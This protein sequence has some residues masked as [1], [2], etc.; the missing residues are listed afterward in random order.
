MFDLSSEQHDYKT[1]VVDPLG[2]F[3][4]LVFASVVGPNGG[5]IEEYGGGYGK[6]YTA[7]LQKW[8]EML[9]LLERCWKARGMNIILLGHAQVKAFQNP[10]GPSYDKWELALHAKTAGMLRQ[11]VDAVLFARLE[12][13]VEVK[14]GQK[15]RGLSSGARVVHTTPSAAYDAGTRWKLPETLPLSWEDLTAAI[16]AEAHRGPELLRSIESMLAELGDADVRTFSEDFVAK[17]RTNADRLAELANR[18]GLRL[19]QK[20]NAENA[21]K[22]STTT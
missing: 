21:T 13:F 6:G 16:A 1:I 9:S 15:A 4:P 19:E 17:N 18:I 20:K 5:S 12:T 11:W 3:E 8:R 10:E 22:G 2:W 14:K 7:A